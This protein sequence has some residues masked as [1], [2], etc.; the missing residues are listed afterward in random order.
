MTNQQQ[1]LWHYDIAYDIRQI[2]CLLQPSI[3]QIVI[4]LKIW[5]E[6]LMSII[7][8]LAHIILPH[9]VNM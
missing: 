3:K 5:C 9:G 2:W 4:L 7:L 1:Y 8:H 6:K